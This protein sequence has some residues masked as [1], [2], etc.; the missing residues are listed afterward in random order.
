MKAAHHI[1]TMAMLT[2]VCASSPAFSQ[3]SD[4]STSTRS[5]SF[6]IGFP[7]DSQPFQGQVGLATGIFPEH[8]GSNDH[9]ATALPLIDIRKRNAYFLRGGST[10]IN[11]G[12]ASAGVTLLHF[13]YAE[14]SRRHIQLVMGPLIRAY[15]GRDESD[16]DAL[17]GL[18]D[19]DP[20]IGV[21][22]F[23]A[24][25]AGSW[26]ANL[27]MSPQDTGN[28]NDGTLATFDITHTAPIKNGL[29]LSTSL[30]TSWADGDYMRGYY[31]VSA[32]QA[33]KSG[34]SPF[35]TGSG[36]KDTGLQVKLSYAM[37]SRLSLEGEIGY[38]RLLNDAAD[39]PIVKND[40]SA[41]QVRSFVGLTYLL[42]DI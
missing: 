26:L 21:G 16:S 6:G 1:V 13:S 29:D 5:L 10:N 41:D 39:S 3:E 30:S 7:E 15:A 17:N 12:L 35:D 23:I 42:S 8:E 14:E 9:A 24:F 38:W 22:G 27:S 18:G 11:N 20:G 36:L 37:S 19:I 2:V 25:S 33:A 40:G 31:G 32:M 4:E 28:G 34:Y